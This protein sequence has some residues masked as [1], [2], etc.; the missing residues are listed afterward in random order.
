M[1]RRF[2]TGRAYC[3]KYGECLAQILIQHALAQ[4]EVDDRKNPARRKEHE[5][6]AAVKIEDAYKG[7]EKAGCPNV[8]RV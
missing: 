6:I 8:K 1:Q 5:T 2:C 7:A 3:Q 4:Q